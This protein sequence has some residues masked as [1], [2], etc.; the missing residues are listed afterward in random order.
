M[1]SPKYKTLV[2]VF[3]QK[4]RSG[5]WAAGSRLPTHRLAA[6]QYGIALAT[7]TKAYAELEALGLVSGETGRGTYVRDRNV[8]PGYGRIPEPLRQGVIDLAFNYPFSP[9]QPDALRKALKALSATGD[10]SHLM[11]AQPTRGREQERHLVAQHLES[12]GVEAQAP[13]LLLVNGA[14]QGL[15]LAVLAL[16]Q[17]GDVVAVDALTYPGFIALA[18]THRLDLVPIAMGA[19]GPD[20]SD[21][22]RVLRERPVKAIYTMPTLHNPMGWVMNRADRDCLVALAR[23]YDV[24]LIEDGTY[25]F[26][27]TNAPAPVRSLAPERT[28]YVGGLSK[29]V[30]GGVRFGFVLAPSALVAVL[31]R[32]LR[33]LTWSNSTIITALCGHWLADGTV[34]RM[35]REKRDDAAARQ[36]MAEV[37]LA[38]LNTIANPASYFVWLMLPPE[39]RADQLAAWLMREGVL[40]ATSEAFATAATFPHAIRL[41]LGG[42][43]L[44]CLRT[45]L[46]KVRQGVAHFAI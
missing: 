7:A 2:D 36:R 3:A 32:T 9:N 22:A 8:P 44:E 28:V 21:L 23:Q 15:A 33:A 43:D 42:V 11:H 38:G 41:S 24:L 30:G 17:P 6:R 39:V 1:T 18:Q 26:L 46:Q 13:D 14:Q 5:E 27:M 10:L 45:A 12:R 16:L 25:A 20:L 4:I 29:I 37:E 19:H 35:E 31:E 34:A 40:V